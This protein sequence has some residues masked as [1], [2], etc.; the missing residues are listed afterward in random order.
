MP[1]LARELVDCTTCGGKGYADSSVLYTT[2]H[3]MMCPRCRGLGAVMP[4]GTELDDEVISLYRAWQIDQARFH[5]RA[6][7]TRASEALNAALGGRFEMWQRFQNDQEK[8][9]N[10]SNAPSWLRPNRSGVFGANRTLD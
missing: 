7:Q 9:G 5:Y 8:R 10:G 6:L 3:L 2:A 1:K 4:D